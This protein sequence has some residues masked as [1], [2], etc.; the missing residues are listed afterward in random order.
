MSTQSLRFP[1]DFLWGT[2]TAAYQIEG[3]VDEDGRGESIWDRF[4]HTEGAIRNGENGDAACDHYHRWQQDVALMK[5]IH[6]RAYRFSIAWSRVQPL[7]RGAVNRKGLDFY[8]RLVDELLSAGIT[9]FVT[10]YHWDLPQALEEQG[11]WLR[12]GIV[13]DFAAYAEVAAQA[14]GDRVRHWITLNEPWVFAWLGY[15]QGVHAPG[16]KSDAPA[17]ALT[18]AHHALLAHGRAVAVVR[19]HA[20]AA[21]VGLSNLLLHFE[22]ATSKSTDLEA[23]ARQD[24]YFN[25]WFFDP[26]F[27]GHYPADKLDEW[28]AYLP[29]IEPGD[30]QQIAAPLDFIG[31]NYYTRNIIAADPEDPHRAVVRIPPT[32]GTTTMGWEV[33]PQGLYASLKRIHSE[34]A[35]H[36]LYVTENGAAYDDVVTADGQV[37]DEARTAYLRDHFQAAAHAIADGVPLKGYFVWSLMDNFEWAEGYRQ[38]FGLYYTDYTTQQR[39]LKDSGRYFATVA[40]Q[41]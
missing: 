5:A 17:D 14:L 26:L 10:L 24:G 22:P 2:A 21:Q 7:G 28:E 9:P 35:P 37:H 18:A 36:A 31:I 33:Y 27:R 39:I 4:A 13:D 38:R 41:A 34:Y 19:Q 6:S 30:M 29:K 11:G 23:A 12:R 16:R 20:P 15:Q 3:G 25:R 40:R 8:S 32:G 1:A